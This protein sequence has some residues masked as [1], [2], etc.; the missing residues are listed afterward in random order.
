MFRSVCFV[1][2]AMTHVDLPNGRALACFSMPFAKGGCLLQPQ[3]DALEAEYGLCARVQASP[4]KGNAGAKRQLTVTGPKGKNF[5]KCAKEA[6]TLI[7]SNYEKGILDDPLREGEPAEKPKTKKGKTTQEARQE[8]QKAKLAKTQRSPPPG[9]PGAAWHSWQGYPSS[10][11]GP[12]QSHPSSGWDPKMPMQQFPHPMLYQPPPPC[13]W[14]PGMPG[15]SCGYA[16]PPPLGFHAMHPPPPPPPLAEPPAYEKKKDKVTYG[17]EISDGDDATEGSDIE[18]T[19]IELD[20]DIT[21]KCIEKL[22]QLA[23]EGMKTVERLLDK[24]SLRES[25]KYDKQDAAVGKDWP[26]LATK[27]RGLWF[28]R[29]INGEAKKCDLFGRGIPNATAPRP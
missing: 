22:S 20:V 1:F 23:E 27:A 4:T 16:P 3:E 13:C 21:E 8:E 29:E 28:V 18:K 25:K 10:S 17:G 7:Q 24:K 5:E 14:V 11:W 12:W 2:V 19:A 26:L 9:L 15:P 6:M